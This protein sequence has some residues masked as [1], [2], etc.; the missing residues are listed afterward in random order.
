SSLSYEQFSAFLSN[1]K[2]LNSQNQ[3]RGELL[4]KAEKLGLKRRI[5]SIIIGKL[6]PSFSF[7]HTCND[8]YAP[9]QR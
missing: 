1:I 8:T 4:R 7:T 2:E 6:H 3:T 5:P 9:T